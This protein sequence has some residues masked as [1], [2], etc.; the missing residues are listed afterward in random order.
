MLASFC[1]GRVSWSLQ[2]VGSGA[3]KA[4]EKHQQI[5][6]QRVARLLLDR[7]RRGVDRAVPAEREAGDA[8]E[9]GDVLV[10]LADRLLQQ[11]DLDVAGLLGEFARMDDVAR[12]GVQRAQQRRG[13]TAGRAESGAGRDIG[14]RRDLDLRSPRPETA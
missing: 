3:R 12:L 13:E 5:V 10:L 1:F 11:V 2:D 14:Q 4:G 9:S 8:A 6:L 7:Q